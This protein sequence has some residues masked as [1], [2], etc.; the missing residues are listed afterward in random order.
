MLIGCFASVM[1]ERLKQI[2][3]RHANWSQAQFGL[4]SE[5]GPIYPIRHL[6]LEVAELRDAPNDISEAADCYLL[7]SD[8]VRRSGRTFEDFVQAIETKL[9]INEKRR[10]KKP[11][12]NGVSEHVE[13]T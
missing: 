13:G 11:D 2:W 7:L 9:S 10:W 3:D 5:R 6:F 12:E 1:I 4:D 8:A